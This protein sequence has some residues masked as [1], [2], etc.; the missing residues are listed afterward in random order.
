MQFEGA[1]IREQGTTF[2]VVVV[3]NHVL[4]STHEANET[5]RQFGPVFPGLPVVLMAQSNGRPTYYGRPDIAKF[6]ASVSVSRIPWKRY[7]LN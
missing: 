6:L 3:K 5:I 4:N 7:T 1:V 2:A